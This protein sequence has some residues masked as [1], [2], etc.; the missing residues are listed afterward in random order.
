MI[1]SDLHNGVDQPTL[2]SARASPCNSYNERATEMV[3]R[4][5]RA[6]PLLARL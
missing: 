4:L 1:A 3:N 6:A 2:L 5:I